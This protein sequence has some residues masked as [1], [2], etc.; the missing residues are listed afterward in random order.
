VLHIWCLNTESNVPIDP[1]T[2]T[3]NGRLSSYKLYTSPQQ[4]S[5]EQYDM[6]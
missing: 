3:N 2:C 5:P 1:D 6:I 4:H